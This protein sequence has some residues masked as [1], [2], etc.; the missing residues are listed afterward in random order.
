MVIYQAGIVSGADINREKG[1]DHG[2]LG[3][4]LGH[5]AEDACGCI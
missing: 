2:R 3:E 4:L 1:A 5:E